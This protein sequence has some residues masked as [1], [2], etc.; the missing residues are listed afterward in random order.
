MDGIDV[1]ENCG[2]L[3]TGGW[4]HSFHPLLPNREGSLFFYYTYGN[5]GIHVCIK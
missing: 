1:G 2:G 3:K 5:I 4:K